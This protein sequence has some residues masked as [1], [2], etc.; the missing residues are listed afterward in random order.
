MK[1]MQ[2]AECRKQNIGAPSE[3]VVRASSPF[4][5]LHSSFCIDAS[6]VR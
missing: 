5:I 6:E 2:N 4:F 1:Q 3:S